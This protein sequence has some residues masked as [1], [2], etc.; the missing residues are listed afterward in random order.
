MSAHL[1]FSFSAGAKYEP[2][3]TLE[4]HQPHSPLLQREGAVMPALS[5]ATRIGSSALAL[6]SYSLVPCLALIL[7]SLPFASA[8]NPSAS[9]IFFV[10]PSISQRM[11]FFGSPSLPSSPLRN[12]YIASGPHTNTLYGSFAYFLMRSAVMNPC[13]KPSA[14]SSERT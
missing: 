1:L 9:A 4:R 3:I 7:N 8:G 10:T 5:I 2:E 14:S 12:L 6:K 13:P 11:F